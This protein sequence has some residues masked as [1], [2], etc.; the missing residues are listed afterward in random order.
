MSAFY[1]KDERIYVYALVPTKEKER[2]PV[3]KKL[4]VDDKHTIL[5]KEFGQLTAVVCNLDNQDFSKERIEEHAQ[6]PSWITVKATHHH[7]VIS[8]L[9]NNCT[10]LPLKFCTIYSNEKSLKDE[11]S[12]KEE[13]ICRLLSYFKN[14][15][16]WNVKIYC[17]KEKVTNYVNENN[18]LIK[19]TKQKINKMSPGKQFLMKKK[20]DLVLLKSV[21]EEIETLTN[22][23]HEKIVNLSDQY[24]PKKIWNKQIT[25]KKEDMVWNGVYLINN[26]DATK[27]FKLDVLQIQKEYEEIGFLLECTGP[28][29]PYDFSEVKS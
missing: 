6:D 29:P 7:D 22:K 19:E 28:W 3:I 4:G 13:N 10:V 26:G 9:H 12:R 11:L 21:N 25:G 15:E 23:I 17:D 8:T 2:F 20:F 14:R 16:G 5:L 18:P 27:K 1:N 24:T